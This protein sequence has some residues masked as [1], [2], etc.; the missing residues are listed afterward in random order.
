MAVKVVTDSTS[1]IPRDL[2]QSLGITIVPLEVNLGTEVFKDGV[3]LSSEEFFR[4]LTEGGVHPTT[5]QPPPGEFIQAYEELSKE[6][7]AIVSI[8]ISSKLSGTLNSAEQAKT[9]A[10]I[11]C[12]VEIVDSLHASIGL[13]MITI[14][15]AHAANDGA[16]LDEV[17]QAARGAMSRAQCFPLL[18][19]LEFLQKGGRVGKAPG[20][21]RLHTEDQAHNHREGRGGAPSR[22]GKDLCQRGRQA[23]GV[24]TRVCSDRGAMRPTQHHARRGPR[25]GREPARPAARG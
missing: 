2:A 22:Q 23:P 4:R 8:H 21:D 1:E 18:D 5:S 10:D 3:D 15:A 17:T 20:A 13:G 6:A 19:T 12:P 11:K 25:L 9:Q 7:D 14:A 16:S 24:G